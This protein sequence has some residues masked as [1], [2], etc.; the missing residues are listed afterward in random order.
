MMKTS[1]D[2]QQKK[3]NSTNLMSKLVEENDCAIAFGSIACNLPESL[4]HEARLGSNCEQRHHDDYIA[5][6]RPGCINEP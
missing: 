6:T 5:S 2:T 3:V 4:T 1:M